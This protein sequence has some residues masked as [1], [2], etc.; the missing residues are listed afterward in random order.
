MGSEPT[1]LQARALKAN[2]HIDRFME[3]DLQFSCGTQGH[4]RCSIWGWP[5]IDASLNIYGDEGSIHVVN[6]IIPHI[7]YHHL[8][9]KTKKETSTER[10]WGKTTYYCQLRAFVAAIH[11]GCEYPTTPEDAMNNMKIIDEIYKKA[12]MEPRQGL[13]V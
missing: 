3:A 5:P 1:V 8:K 13:N 7:L 11:E 10:F 9:I 4:I 12:G 2:A 6:P